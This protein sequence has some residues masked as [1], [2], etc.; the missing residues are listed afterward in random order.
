MG[1]PNALGVGGAGASLSATVEHNNDGT[2]SPEM[3]QWR[4]KNRARGRGQT[5]TVQAIKDGQEAQ[6]SYAMSFTAPVRRQ[7]GHDRAWNAEEGNAG[8]VA[9][10]VITVHNN[11]SFAI[12]QKFSNYSQIFTATQK[13]PKTKVVQNQ[14]LYNFAFETIQNSAYILK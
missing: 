6:G 14:K 13:S 10:A 3:K 8:N 5:A 1:L 4:R 11:Y 9:S 12:R 7:N 2:G